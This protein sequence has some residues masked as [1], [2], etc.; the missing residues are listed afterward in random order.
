MFGFG[1]KKDK[2]PAAEAAAPA[3]NREEVLAKIEEAKAK[4][5]SLEGVARANAL[6]EL[7]KLHADIDQVDE[8]IAAYE[9]SLELNHVMGKASS[10]L[11]KLYN[12]KRAQAA[13]AKDDEK[14][15]YYLDKVNEMLAL[16]KDSLRGRA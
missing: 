15:K 8:A 10:S 5:A 12:K 16:S 1:K 14:I 13:E 11:V 6:I 9:E 2:A 4:V 3:M 7:G